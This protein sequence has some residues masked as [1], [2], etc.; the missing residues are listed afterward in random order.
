MTNKQS[1]K[2][3]DDGPIRGEDILSFARPVLKQVEQVFASYTAIAVALTL[4][5][6]AAGNALTRQDSGEAP[7][8]AAKVPAGAPEE[9]SALKALK[10]TAEP[11]HA[12]TQQR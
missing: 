8:P 7:P 6:F 12:P 10:E 3:E 2:P 11:R 5:V 4:G 1:Q 9:K